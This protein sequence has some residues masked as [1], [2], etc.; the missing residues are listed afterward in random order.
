M[1]N[2]S[3]LSQTIVE[4]AMGV[5]QLDDATY[6]SIEHDANATTQAAIVVVVVGLATGIGGIRDSVANILLGPI[7]QIISWAI[8]SALVYFVGTKMI[9]SGST[10]ADLGQVLRLMGYASVPAAANILGFIPYLGALIGFVAAIWGLVCTIKAI[11]HALEM[12]T[13]R[14]IATGIIA[15]L[16]AAIPLALIGLGVF[17]AS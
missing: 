10:E 15:S 11:K 6:E 17:V 9:P 8:V 5:L 3:A 16:L 13:G 12:S 4:R 14:A 1:M 2:Q 7:G